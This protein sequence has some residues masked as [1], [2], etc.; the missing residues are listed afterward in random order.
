MLEIFRGM[1]RRGGRRR[2]LLI[3]AGI[4]LLTAC[5][6]PS[7]DATAPAQPSSSVAIPAGPSAVAE[8]R[9]AQGALAGLGYDPGPVDG[10]AGP[11]TRAA[12]AQY[13]SDVGLV[14]DGEISPELVARLLRAHPATSP[15]ATADPAAAPTYEA[16]DAYAYTDGQ[17]ET[18]VS[19]DEHRVEWRN[20]AGS[21]WSSARDFPLPSNQSGG[22]IAMHRPLAWPLEVGATAA[23]STAATA[24]AAA[25]LWRCT[26]DGRQRTAVPAGAFDTFRIVCEPDAGNTAKTRSR[27]W[28]YAPAIG[29]YVRYVDTAASSSNEATGSRSRDLIAVS[30]SV[31]GWPS[32]ARIGLEWALSHAL[33]VEPD[34]QPVHWGSSAIPERF[35]I[36]PGPRLEVGNA[37]QCRQ[38]IKTRTA[39]N[40]ARRDYPGAACRSA[41]G[42]WQ[43][44]GPQ[45]RS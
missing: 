7:G 8:V 34:G 23:Y 37:G 45:S 28:Y 10:I 2:H 17:I 38:F 11:K 3:S 30:H 24:S 26:V 1:A 44:M 4:A 41:A 31:S 43:L 33:E 22:A 20:A 13:Q 42:Q 27:T 18:V 35:V 6:H 29:S 39:G 12:V 15:V 9:V 5:S 25:E 16:G 32:E 40:G 21:R 14:P 36:R 19:A